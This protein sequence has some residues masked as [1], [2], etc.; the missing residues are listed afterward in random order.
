MSAHMWSG[1]NEGIQLQGSL[2]GGTG[3]PLRH[4]DGIAE[5]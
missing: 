3:L 1:L 4:S 2:E 5:L